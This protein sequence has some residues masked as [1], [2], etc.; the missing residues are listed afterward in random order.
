MF[1]RIFKHL[2]PNAKAWRITIDKTLRRFFEG[3]TGT[4]EDVKEFYDDIY[5]DINP[6]T[7]RQLVE[8]ETQFGLFPGN[9]TGQERRD[10]LDATWK[11]TG[12]QSPGYLQATLQAA[13]FDVYVHEW[14]EPIGGRSGGSVD[15]DVVPVA[16]NP[17]VYLDDGTGTQTD[18][19]CDNTASMVDGA[20]EA[21]DGATGG[22]TGYALVNNI[23]GDNVIAAVPANYPYYLYIGG[24]IFPA[25][26]TIS[27]SRRAEFETLCLKTCPAQQ[28]LGI[29]VDYS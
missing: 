26:A 7:T 28:W 11:A 18:I 4:G 22:A 16:R 24:E 25:H 15:G 13:G 10:R 27:G 6:L 5:D 8:W 19:A 12:G 17:L 2:L 20:V 9:L 29:L 23:P 1:L 14:W 3:L 21:V